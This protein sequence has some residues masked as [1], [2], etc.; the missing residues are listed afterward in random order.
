MTT[1][2]VTRAL[3]EVKSLNDRINRANSTAFIS[4]TVGGKHA[5]GN[6]VQEVELQL[7]SQLQS[8]K[9][10]IARRAA[11]KAA[12]VVSNAKTKV[13]VN[14]VEMT[15]AEAIERKASIQLDKNLLQTLKTQRAQTIAVIERTN[16]QVAN[17]SHALVQTAVGK[18]RKASEEEIAAITG[19][20]RA[21]NEAVLL[22]PSKLEQV[23][24][25]LQNDIDG[26]ELDVDHALNEINAVTKLSI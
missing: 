24:N 10:L 21:Q 18:D 1:I 23:I 17:Q 15:V 11:L 16:L 9:D 4:Y 12:I 14:N 26:F 5:S 8:V 25:E 6:A 3:A 7:K 19:P 20:F 2:S 22:D 13:V